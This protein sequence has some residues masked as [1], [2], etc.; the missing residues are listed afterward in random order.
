MVF[1]DDSPQILE[2]NPIERSMT[3]PVCVTGAADIEN[4]GTAL[5]RHGTLRTRKTHTEEL[6]HVVHRIN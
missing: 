4:N 3:R 6:A 1:S 5:W 2:V